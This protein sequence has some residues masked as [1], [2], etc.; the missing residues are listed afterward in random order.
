MACGLA[1]I[2]ALDT[3]LEFH[4]FNWNDVSNGDQIIALMSLDVLKII[5]NS[6]SDSSFSKSL[7]STVSGRGKEQL[8]TKNTLQT[9][10]AWPSSLNAGNRRCTLYTITSPF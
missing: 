1:S 7:T 6:V 5:E 2:F 4:R 10:E 8:K 9:E 3:A